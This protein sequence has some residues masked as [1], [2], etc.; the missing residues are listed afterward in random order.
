MSVPQSPPSLTVVVP[1]YNERPNIA[2]LVRA[3]RASLE[4][5]RWELLFVDDDSPDGTLE[6]ID[7]LA[8]EDGRIRR[9]RR[10]GRRGLA[11]AC[12][13]GVLA[14]SAPYVAI[15]DGDAQHD[16]ALLKD[17]LARAR[18]DGCD[19]VVAS[20]RET[21]GRE[22]F[23]G[24]LRRWLTRFGN[25]LALLLVGAQ[26]R[27]PLS[28]YF[29]VRRQVFEQRAPVLY[30]QG[31]KLL[32]DLL[33]ASREPLSIAEVPMA[34]RP[35]AAGESKMGLGVGLDAA[36]LL[37]YR[38]AG[39]L[40]S[41]RFALY[42]LVGLTGV[43]VHLLVLQAS[44]GLFEQRFV[45]AQALA[46]FVAMTSNFFLNNAI[47]F[48][49]RRLRGRAMVRGLLSFY[50]ACTA[51]AIV[52]VAVGDLLFSLALPLWLA[53]VGGALVAAIWNFSLNAALTWRTR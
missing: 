27:D 14:S 45:P 4:G 6:E 42:C 31:F 24:P 51:G 2:P 32:V 47:T 12:I 50:L 16:P 7:R 37:I 39:R 35:R 19:V 33:S 15:M 30:G 9:L 13:E 20:R 21:A 18:A 3:V 10:I 23:R 49:D 52:S 48:G 28:G 34:L 17:L 29:L 25:A 8:A 5:E 43:G 22:S 46:T 26:A 40:V 44:F 11:S 38:L 53:G 1:T 36:L 41:P